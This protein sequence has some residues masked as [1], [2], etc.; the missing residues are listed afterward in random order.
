MSEHL[1]DMIAADRVEAELANWQPQIALAPADELPLRAKLAA[2]IAKCYASISAVS[3][4]G[5]NQHHKYKF[6]S[7]EAIYGVARAGMSDSGLALVPMMQDHTEQ[8]RGSG[9]YLQMRWQFALMDAETGYALVIPWKSEVYET[10][11]DKGLNKLATAATKYLLRTLFLIP[12]DADSD[13]DSSGGDG[14]REPVSQPQRN[15]RRA[16][17]P[18]APAA[19][20]VDPLREYTR[21]LGSDADLRAITAE[22]KAAGLKPSEVFAT[23]QRDGLSLQ[24]LRGLLA[25]PPAGSSTRSEPSTT[26]YRLELTTAQADAAKAQATAH[27][28]DYATVFAAAEATGVQPDAF[29]AYVAEF[30]GLN[31]QDGAA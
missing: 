18:E 5:T 4:D 3:K 27:G 9:M 24:Q 30:A 8:A 17:Q 16:R 31:Q 10:S 2:K 21:A 26:P 12:T 20:A 22:I 19:P 13:P 15:A 6:A 28:V 1:H 14:Q 11:I 29:A 23:G 7:T 25:I